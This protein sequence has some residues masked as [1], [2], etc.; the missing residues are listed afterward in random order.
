MTTDVT[1]VAGERID[2]AIDG[3]GFDEVEA[4]PGQTEP[5]A[6]FTVI[7]KHSDLAAVEDT[8]DAIS[9]SVD[10]DGRV[11]DVLSIPAEVLDASKAYEVISWPSRSFPTEE[12]LYARADIAIDWATL[13]PDGGQ[14]RVTVT[15]TTSSTAA[16]VDQEIELTA[17]IAP[18]VDGTVTFWNGND[19]LGNA[20]HAAGGTAVLTTTL[21]VGDHRITASFVPDADGAVESTSNPVSVTVVERSEEGSLQWGVKSNFRSYVTGDIAGGRITV[22]EGAKQ[23]AGNGVFT[24][25]QASAGN[26]WN[27]QTGTVQYAG[28][29]TFFGHSGALN[30]TIANPSIRVLDASVA[31]LRIN[32]HG[33]TIVFATIDLASA[34]RQALAG[35]AVRFSSAPATLTQAGA[36]FFSYQGHEFYGPGEALDRVTFTI[37]Q[38]SDVGVAD[39]PTGSEGQGG[40]GSASTPVDPAPPAAEDSAAAGSLR[41][42]VSSAFVAYTTCDGKEQFGYSHCAK[43]S[44][45]TSGVG[46]GYLF[47]QA[48]GSEWDAETQTG[49]VRYSGVVSFLGYG[50]TM[51]SVSNPSIT[52]HGPGS[53]TLH[54]GN[55]ANFGAGSYPLDLS[56]ATK[57]D[58]ENGEVTWSG[59]GV[60]GSLTGGPGGGSANSIGFD[61]LTFTVGTAS[62]ESFGSTTAGDGDATSVAAETAP[63]TTGIELLTPADQIRAGGRIQLQASGFE[64]TEFG[65]LVVLYGSDEGSVPIVLDE[66]ASANA[67]GLVRWSG[68]LPDDVA[69][70]HV[71]TLQGSIDAGA[72][73][74]I[75]ERE[76]P[77]SAGAA[78]SDGEA[79]P[80]GHGQPALGGGMALWEWWT[81]AASLVAIAGCT[82]TLAV[83]QHRTNAAAVALA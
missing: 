62:S 60:T 76:G 31:E 69:G 23:A 20:V 65:V 66:N 33:D 8:Q 42:G 17:A 34:A 51:F 7:E 61:D 64:T 35:D 55:T 2:I 58:G 52:V 18:D 5:H 27:G 39:P 68:T 71:I 54:T 57:T 80:S 29:V 19:R 75:L 37:G 63:T 56:S 14:E 24:F 13:F 11:S 70:D 36:Q 49:T 77:A 50:M 81:I 53:A 6:Y 1:E 30:H 25:P 4:L 59:V 67:D 3:A 45:S 38:A 83:R 48:A 41:W 10:V 22:A 15:L 72:E 26:T 32:Y 28:H 73:I 16:Y 78:I 47:P 9:A 74:E 82:S 79:G 44:V 21:P 46:S 40:G 12:N 43:G